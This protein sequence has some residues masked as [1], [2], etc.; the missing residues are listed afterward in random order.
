MNTSIQNNDA[1]T[2]KTTRRQDKKSVNTKVNNVINFQ[3]GLIA[4]LVAAFLIIEMNTAISNDSFIPKPKTKTLT[5]EPYVGAFTIVPNEPVKVE[6]AKPQP[7]NDQPQP[8]IDKVLPPVPVDDDQIIDDQP[9]QDDHPNSKPLV[10]SDHS[11]D[12][13]GTD[14]PVSAPKAPSNS[15]IATV[16][17]VPLFPGCSAGLDRAG[18]ID[19]LNKKM[20]RFVQRKFDTSLGDNIDK[21]LVKI[22]VQF[23]IGVDGLPKDILVR[24]PNADL[25]KE[26]R[27]VISN[28]PKMTPGKVDGAAVN[29]TY[30]LP[31][32]FKVER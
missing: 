31:I 27:K 29:V 22:T 21:D 17:E 18:R 32:N 23:T 3:I 15:L 20:A 12:S 2:S 9:A 7:N 16:H 24:A 30:T 13:A 11:T 8:K 28:L 10:N 14:A 1:A 5:V 19:C 26:A 6:P 4:A 25:E